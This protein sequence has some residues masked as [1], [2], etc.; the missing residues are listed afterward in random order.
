[1]MSSRGAHIALTMLDHSVRHLEESNSVMMVDEHWLEEHAE[2][3]SPDQEQE[4]TPTPG[5][6]WVDVTDSVVAGDPEHYRVIAD[7]RVPN[8]PSPQR[9]ANA[10]V[11]AQALQM[12]AL[13]KR[14][15][16]RS[17]QDQALQRAMPQELLQQGEQLIAEIEM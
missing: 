17:R 7:T 3:I 16:E 6:W 8:V 15:V 4:T 1:M 5:P 14:I 2:L 13:L 12:R 10:V 11:M 9:R